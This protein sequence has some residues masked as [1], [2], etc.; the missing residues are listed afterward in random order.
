MLVLGDLPRFSS[1]PDLICLV[2]V[3]LAVCKKAPAVA[4]TAAP[5]AAP[6]AAQWWVCQPLGPHC[7][8]SVDSEV[9]AKNGST[10]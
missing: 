3:S 8:F 9:L 1:Q 4:P 6:K 10:P 5:T 2:P 7:D